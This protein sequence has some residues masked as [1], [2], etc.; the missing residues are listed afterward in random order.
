MDSLRNLQEELSSKINSLIEDIT[1][2]HLLSNDYKNLNFNKQISTI[3][4]EKDFLI[5]TQGYLRE[6]EKDLGETLTEWLK[7]D[8]KGKIQIKLV[9]ELS[10]EK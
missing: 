3:G 7:N 5:E 1:T 10:Q 6:C 8:C 4:K 2:L 9:T